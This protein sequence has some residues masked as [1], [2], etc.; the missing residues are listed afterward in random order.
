MGTKTASGLL[1]SNISSS[2]VSADPELLLGSSTN[3]KKQHDFILELVYKIQ[4]CFYTF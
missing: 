2:S 3:T 1:D 4:F